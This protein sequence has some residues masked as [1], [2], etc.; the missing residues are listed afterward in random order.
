MSQPILSINELTTILQLNGKNMPV[1]DRLSFQIHRGETVALVGESGCGKSMTALSLL[2]LL[3]TPPCLPSTGEVLFE[4]ENLLLLSE[5]K[6]RKIRGG[7]IAMIFQDPSSALNPVYTIEE[8]MMESVRYHT[9][10]SEKEGKELILRLL[11]EV[12][13]DAP[14]KRLSA[15]P[16]ELSG[17]MKQRVMIAIA[18]IGNPAVLIADEPTTG[19]DVTVQKQVLDLIKKLQKEHGMALLLITHDLGVVASYADRMIVMYTS[20]SVEEGAVFEVLKN[21]SHP[22]TEGL[23]HSLPEAVPPGGKLL[24][25]IGNVPSLA[26]LP[27]GCHFHTRCPYVMDKCLVG[28]VPNFNVGNTRHKARCWLRE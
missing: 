15:Y 7:K 2:K 24:P 25:I 5:R 20:R 10:L 12:A 23:L 14:E 16:H 21:I 8:Q 22:Y 1:V 9:S 4:G 28:E 3:P 6:L 27:K 18:L 19:L 13:I 26:D 17:G 11:N